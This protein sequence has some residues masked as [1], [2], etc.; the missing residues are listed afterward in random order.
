MRVTPLQ[1]LA[2]RK[3]QLHG[4]LPDCMV[5]LPLQWLWLEDNNFHGPLP[6]LSPLGQFLKGIP[7]RSLRRNRW[8]PL[9][10]SEKQALED[11]SEPL[12][13]PTHE[14]GHDWDFG[15]SYEWEWASGA[16]DSGLTAER[17]VSYRQ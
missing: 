10:A 17:E 4:M 7:S 15:Y 6:E 16:A 5:T 3:N 14:H 12:G 9:L 1:V 2:L 13:V 8:T 11:V